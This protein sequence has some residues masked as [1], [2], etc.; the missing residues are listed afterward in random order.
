[1][2]DA[3][4]RRHKKSQSAAN[5]NSPGAR[6]VTMFSAADLPVQQVEIEVF[7]LLMGNFDGAAANDN[8]PPPERRAA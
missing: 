2:A 5:D 1:M 8:D 6:S 7:D 4:I 3:R